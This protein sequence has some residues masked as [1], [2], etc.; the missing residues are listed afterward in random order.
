MY[1]YQNAMKPR[2]YETIIMYDY[3]ENYLLRPKNNIL[4]FQVYGGK[5][6]LMFCSQWNGVALLRIG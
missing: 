2:L 3:V 1:Q 5:N 6:I 4:L